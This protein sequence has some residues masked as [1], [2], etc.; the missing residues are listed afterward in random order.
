MSDQRV[1]GHL[2]WLDLTVPDAPAI[3]DFYADV[4]G[5]TAE[6][7]SMG[8]YEDF[9]MMASD[10]DAIAGICHRRGDN[11]DLP[12][13]WIPYVVV[14]DLTGSVARCR[15]GGGHVLGGIREMGGAGLYAFIRDPAG[16]VLALFQHTG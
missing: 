10:G 3:R 9:V 2:G 12:A 15:E 13:M 4:V 11:A 14:T 6:P 7:Q 5:W 16:A 8:D 1:P